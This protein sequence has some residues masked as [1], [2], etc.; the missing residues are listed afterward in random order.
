MRGKE[1][2]TLPLPPQNDNEKIKNNRR[3]SLRLKHSKRPF[4]CSKGREM[5]PLDF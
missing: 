5:V 1:R 3:G 4:L 2:K